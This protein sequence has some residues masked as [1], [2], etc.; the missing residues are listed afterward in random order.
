MDNLIAIENCKEDIKTALI[1]KGVDMTG[2]AF[3]GYAEK[4]NALQLESGDTP[5][6]PTPSADY[7]YS[8]GY[9]TGGTEK[10]EI[11]NF[12]PYEI[13]LD[14]DGKFVINLTCPEE[15]PG[16][17]GGTYY[18]VIFTVEIPTTYNITNFELYAEGMS[19]FVPQAYKAN[20]RH[21]TV[22]REGVTY[23]SYVRSSSDGLDIGS[24]DVQYNPLQYK[25]TI[26]KK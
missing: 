12:I 15:I 24:S 22:V 1:N 11:I 16:Y 6:P 25:I 19:Q 14:G 21:T 23:N 2:V 8:N 13:V 20:P 17:E 26:E 5:T 4:I 7:I 9:P 3:T 18:D 10:N